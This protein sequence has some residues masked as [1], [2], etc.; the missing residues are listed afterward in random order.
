MSELEIKKAYEHVNELWQH[1]KSGDPSAL[2]AIDIAKFVADYVSRVNGPDEFWTEFAKQLHDLAV[3][4]AGNRRAEMMIDT[5]AHALMQ[6]I[7]KAGV[8]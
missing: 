6:T 5:V 2:L 3:R 7:T 1:A 4:Y 8:A